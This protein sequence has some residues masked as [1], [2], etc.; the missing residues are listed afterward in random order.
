MGALDGRTVLV[1]GAA[2]GVGRALAEACIAAGARVVIADVL[3]E[4]GRATAARIGARFVAVDLADPDSIASMAESIARTEGVLHGLVNNA[5]IATGIGGPEYDAI[6]IGTWDR[7]MSVNVRGT[8]LVTRALG[9][10]LAESGSGRVVNLASDTALWGAPR[11]LAYVASK[12]AVI[13]MTRSLAREMGPRGIGVTAVAPGILRN[14][15]TEYVPAERHA[16]YETGR[17][18]PGAMVPE[19]IAPTVVFLLTPGAL[20]VTGQVLPVNN[21]FVFA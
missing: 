21:G 16:L 12:G 18:A 2:R 20:A 6:E 14:E 5:A 11:L 13:A 3:A 4:A 9:R 1:T 7:V 10:M 15:A 17:A 8:W 19:D